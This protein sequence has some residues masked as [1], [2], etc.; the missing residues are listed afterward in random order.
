MWEIMESKFYSKHWK[1]S[2]KSYNFI[3]IF[4][5]P[6][7]EQVNAPEGMATLQD[8]I[9]EKKEMS[10]S[11]SSFLHFIANTFGWSFT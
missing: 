4:A 3:F 11:Q 8:S 10:L 5:V 6:A 1:S 9:F 7:P 2:L